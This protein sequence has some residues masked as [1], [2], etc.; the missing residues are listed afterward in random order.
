MLSLT[1]MG[2]GIQLEVKWKVL[3]E[4]EV[5]LIY[6]KSVFFPSCS[7]TQRDMYRLD[8]HKL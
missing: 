6:V 2:E 5:L 8:I 3:L 7:Y 1:G 4:T